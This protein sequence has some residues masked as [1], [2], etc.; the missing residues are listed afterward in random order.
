MSIVID[1]NSDNLIF[2][3]SVIGLGNFD[4]FH[5]GHRKIIKKVLEI[6]KSEGIKSS[7]LLFKQHTNEVFPHFPRYYISSLQDK[8]EILKGYN[9]DYIFT[10]DFT[11]E[12]AQLTNDGF[13]LDF[14][15]DS[16]NAHFLVCGP[17]YTYGKKSLGTVKELYEY[18]EN[19]D[20]DV[21]VQDY[22]MDNNQKISSTLIRSLIVS[23]QV[24]KVKLYLED[25]Y[26]VRGNVIHGFKIGSKELGYP[27]ANIEL[28][29]RYIMPGEG[30]YL[31]NV[32]YNDRKYL[33]LT[34]IGTNPTVTDN[35]DIK[36][37]V[38]ILDFNSSIYGEELQIEFIL[39]MRDQIKFDNK[40]DLIDQMNKDFQFAL[41]YKKEN[42]KFY[43]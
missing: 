13:I 26:K 17:D 15:R 29:F 43:K 35:K 34:S 20:I 42:I 33:S 41:D 32:Y 21:Y 37:E 9:I 12:F 14:I 16:L 11:M 3:K 5:K 28:N 4:G 40:D 39:K 2:D 36:L 38:F 22:V 31:T 18:K 19:N 24:D 6:S 1:L 27:T 10:I 25:N 7:V 30:V 23:G 8:I